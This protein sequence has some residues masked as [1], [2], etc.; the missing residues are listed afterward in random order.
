METSLQLRMQHQPDALN[1]LLYEL[2]DESAKQRPDKD[3]WSIFENIA[4]LGRYHEVFLQRV[5]TILKEQDPLFDRYV[6][7]T[8]EKQLMR[9]GRHPVY[10][11]RNINGWTEFFLLH[12]AHHFYTILKLT[13]QIISPE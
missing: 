9:T 13:S 5:Q 3:K 11:K 8:D 6:A 4:H 1:H 7:D 2:N 12:E 10:G